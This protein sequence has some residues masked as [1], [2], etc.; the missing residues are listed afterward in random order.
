MGAPPRK[1]VRGAAEGC[2]RHSGSKDLKCL[3][4]TGAFRM[5][6]IEEGKGRSSKEEL[7]ER[8]KR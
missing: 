2:R 3:S 1:W 7:L 5:R 4:E 8:M 6:I